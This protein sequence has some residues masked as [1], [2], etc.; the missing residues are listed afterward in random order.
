MEESAGQRRVRTAMMAVRKK[1]GD[2][3][4]F[5]WMLKWGYPPGW[6]SGKGKFMLI[7]ATERYHG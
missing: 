4:W 5:E 2:W 1:R 6:V 7:H 3:P